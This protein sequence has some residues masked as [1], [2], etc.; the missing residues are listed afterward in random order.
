MYAIVKQGS[1]QIQVEK[2]QSYKFDRVLGEPGDE[3]TFKEVLLIGGTKTPKIGTPYVK[4]AEVVAKIVKEVKDK[5]VI[6]F[7]FKRR[8]ASRTKR[9]HRQKYTLLT[10]KDIKS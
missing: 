8:K 4:G 3:I 1:K 6:V 2:G 9:G 5:K 10:I 7:K